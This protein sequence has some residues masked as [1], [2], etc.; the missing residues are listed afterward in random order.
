[1]PIPNEDPI[2]TIPMVTPFTQED[3]VDHDAISFNVEKWLQTPLSGFIIGTASSEESLLSEDEK[4]A[5]MRTVAGSLTGDCFLVGGIDC[6]SVNETLRRAEAFTKAGAEMVRLRLPRSEELVESYFE[7]V[8]PR[9]P[10]P[11]I[12]MHQCNPERFGLAGEPAASAETIGRISSMDGVFGYVTDH[13]IRFETRVRQF[14]PA[15]RKFWI[16]NGSLALTGTFIGCNGITTAFSNVWPTA[17]H[18]I[19]TLGMAG[20]YE[21]AR[22]LQQR[23]QDIDSVMLPYKAAGMKAA[24][25]LLGFKG[26]QP[27]RPSLPMPETEIEHLEK[28]MRESGLLKD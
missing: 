10:V 28:V 12:V 20:H 2:V 16:C 18:E 14:V 25:N 7:Q 11:V 3:Q 17:L 13:D 24:M 27:R 23:V 6:L 19:L 4:L 1:M 8:L 21:E 5:I 15:N 9:C 22:D 26:T